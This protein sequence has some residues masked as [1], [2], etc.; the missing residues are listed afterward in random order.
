MSA[1]R[2]ILGL[3]MICALFASAIAASGASA[4]TAVTCAANTTTGAEQFSDGHCKTAATGNGGFKHVTFT[5]TEAAP[6][7]IKLSNEVTPGVKPKSILKSTIAAAPFVLEATTVEG[8]GTLWN[9][10]SGT[11]MFAAGKGTIIYKGVTNP[12]PGCTV[13]GLPGG[14]GQINTKALKAS[15]LGLTN[16]LKFEPETAPIFAEFELTGCTIAGTYKVVGTLK[17]QTKGATTV[18]KHETVTGEKTLRIGSATG[19]V[20]GLEGEVVISNSTSGTPISLT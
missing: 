1:R 12:S 2:A 16:E 5:A 6:T 19:P 15:T 18:F 17:G 7:S 11:E 13:T 10:V 8:T 9:G 3:C 4:Q 14:A 20:A